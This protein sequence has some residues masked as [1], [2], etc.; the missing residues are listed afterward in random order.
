MSHEKLAFRLTSFVFLFLTVFV[1]LAR[2]QLMVTCVLPAGA[3]AGVNY[4][5]ASCSANGGM[6]PYSYASTTLPT[7]L[8]LNKATGAITG[9]PTVEGNSYSFTVTATDNTSPTRLT[10]S[11]TENGFVVLPPVL[12]I[13]CTAP[14]SAQQGVAYAGSCAAFGGTPTYTFS[15]TGSFPPWLSINATTGA[16]SGTPTGPGTYSFAYKLTDATQQSVTQA[17]NNFTVSAPPVSIGCQAP[18]T[19]QVGVAYMGSCTEHGGT[20]P[21]AYSVTGSSPP[22][23]SINSTTGAITGTPTTIGTYTFG[24][25]VTDGVGQSGIQ[26]V[27]NLVVSP[28]APSISCT[29]PL[30]AQVGV[31]YSGS[32]TGQGGTPPYTFSATGNVP[33]WMTVNSSTGAITGTP[34]TNGTYSFMLQVKD[35]AS[36]TASQPVNNLVVSGT[37]LSIG[38]SAPLT[39]QVGVAYAGSCTATG[40]APPYNFAAVGNVPPWL[41]INSTTGAI[42][43]TP[44]TN[45]TYTFGLKVTDNVGQ[46]VSQ[47]VTNL[48][49]SVAAPAI[50]CTAPLTAQV[51]V[52]YAGSCTARGGTPPYTFSATG[53]VPPWLMVNTSTGALTGTPNTNGTYSFTLQVMDNASQTASQSVNNLVVSGMALSLSCVLPG[54][55]QV[56]MAYSASCTASGGT[57]SYTYSISASAPGGLTINPAGTISGVP[58]TAGSFTFAVSVSDNGNP[59]QTA[60]Q[61]ITGFVVSPLS[62]PAVPTFSFVGVPTSQTPGTSITGETISLSTSSAA[63]PIVV[64][65]SFQPNAAGV[66]ANYIDP[67]LQFLDS[68]GNKLGTTYSVTVPALTNS[69]SL[70]QIAPGT[71]AGQISLNLTVIGQTGASSTVTVPL[72]APIITPG[73]VQIT[74][75]TSSGFEV[76][77]VGNSSPRDL[78]T[79]TFTFNA[80]SGAVING[81]TSFSV[82]VS[83]LMNGWYASGASQQFGS[84]FLLTVPFTFSGSSSA[85][86]SV[87]VTLINSQGTSSPV[88]GTN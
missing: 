58:T 74:S 73:S 12:A 84:E 88:T 33:P 6:P 4:Q 79:A 9:T 29:A 78:K 50:S 42:S 28:A 59:K 23:L 64:A 8:V 34:T 17:V 46:T 63:W 31:P 80:G 77:V 72:S 35:N 37:A 55:A 41:T 38:C 16:I 81:T 10:G 14:A 13:N 51:G 53:N 24:L 7:G 43:G 27:T 52:A 47:A 18:L 87:T 1:T 66:P 57:P 49:V 20:P 76:E 67:A 40:G 83:S 60:S 75:V 86:G 21:F 48:V 32:C 65:L 25:K 68:A 3:R 54:N 69:I 70:P 15:L 62:G 61:A 22:W 71:V 39:A 82:D 44:T 45:A 85:I 30:T 2:A 36:Q 56:G 11:F 26:A 5:G 19:A